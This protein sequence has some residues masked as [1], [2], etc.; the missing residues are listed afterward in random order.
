MIGTVKLTNLLV[1][2]NHRILKLMLAKS[3]KVKHYIFDIGKQI[4]KISEKNIGIKPPTGKEKKKK[5]K[6]S[7]TEDPKICTLT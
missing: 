4:P 6:T 7:R 2:D 1:K 3:G 5:K